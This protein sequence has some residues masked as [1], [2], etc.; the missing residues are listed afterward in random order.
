MDFNSILPNRSKRAEAAPTERTTMRQRPNIESVSDRLVV[1]QWVR[2]A[3]PTCVFFWENDEKGAVQMREARGWAIVRD[4]MTDGQYL[5]DSEK[6]YTGSVVS[7]PVG[8]GVTTGNLQAV[9]MM[10]PKEWY[11]EDLKAQEAQ[12]REVAKSLRRESAYFGQV[13]DDGTYDPKLPNGQIGF[14]QRLGGK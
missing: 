3:Y 7:I 2:D 10:M 11:V 4:D 8:P 12:N 1:P 14:D 6:K 5:T 13:R 9:L